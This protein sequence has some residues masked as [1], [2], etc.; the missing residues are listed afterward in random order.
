VVP[1]KRELVGINVLDSPLAHAF[2]TKSATCSATMLCFARQRGTG[3]PQPLAVTRVAA[4][5][6][7]SKPRQRE[8]TEKRAW[9]AITTPHG[10]SCDP[11]PTA[12][13]PFPLR[14]WGYRHVVFKPS[15]P[16]SPFMAQSNGAKAMRDFGIE[17]P[18]H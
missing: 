12:P 14:L 13:T 16:A 4:F 18:A 6:S 5:H 15:A 8:G 1:G 10:S 11:V 17:L 7:P 9:L 2:N 3:C